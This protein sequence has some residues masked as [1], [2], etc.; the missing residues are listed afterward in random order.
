MSE[1]F[2]IEQ[3]IASFLQHLA[4]AHLFEGCGAKGRQSMHLALRTHKYA[5]VRWITVQAC[6]N[7]VPVGQVNGIGE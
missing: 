6:T 1:I 4:K 7:E 2:G 3:E 5:H